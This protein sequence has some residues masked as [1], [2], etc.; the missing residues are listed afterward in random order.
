MGQ[1]SSEIASDLRR[2]LARLNRRLRLQGRASGLSPTKHSI[3]GQSHREGAKNPKAL[4]LAEGVQPQSITRVLAELEEAGFILRKQDQSDHRQFQLEITSNGRELVV[5]D[6][7]SR[8]SWLACAM[9]NSLTP[10]EKDLLRLS[11]PLLDK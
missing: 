3:L 10:L 11:I 2:V 6:A 5:Q 8:A 1:E 9:D 4:A 7:R